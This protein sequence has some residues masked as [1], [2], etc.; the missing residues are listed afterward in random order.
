MGNTEQVSRENPVSQMLQA[1]M[2]RAK[3]F[4]PLHCNQEQEG[5]E[6]AW[7]VTS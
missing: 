7:R 5:K 2:P 6:E 1:R 3:L 4:S